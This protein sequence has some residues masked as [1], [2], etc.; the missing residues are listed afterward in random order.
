[1]HILCS[2][3][4]AQTGGNYLVLDFEIS[5]SIMRLGSYKTEIVKS[6]VRDDTQE[7]SCSDKMRMNFTFRLKLVHLLGGRQ[8][9][10][11]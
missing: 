6:H 8:V 4:Q 11:S 5:Q 2:V 1:M 10:Y 7:V 9:G 3:M